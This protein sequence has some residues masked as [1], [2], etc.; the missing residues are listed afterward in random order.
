MS[1]DTLIIGIA[2]GGYPALRE[3]FNRVLQDVAD[4]LGDDDMELAYD[5]LDLDEEDGVD[6]Q[7][8]VLLM[9]TALFSRAG[10]G[11]SA[12]AVDRLVAKAG[13]GNAVAK[14]IA[15]R[16]PT[17]T[18]SLFEALGHHPEGGVRA[19]DM[20]AGHEL[21][22]MDDGLAANIEA[23][24]LFAGRFVA[25]GP[26]HIGFGVVSMLTRAEA[27]ALML[28]AAIP[29]GRDELHEIVYRSDLHGEALVMGAIEPI[30][31]ALSAAINDSAA[32]IGEIA[33]RIGKGFE[34]ATTL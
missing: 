9:D 1:D 28:A 17:A 24:V 4:G 15:S 33:R 11:P 22:I 10:E 12:R 21:H 29:D 20:L 19:R 31:A 6:E 13:R 34:A 32:P 16:L 27:V 7:S 5:L 18:F 8:A 30:I 26:W 23:G 14:A 25:L 3:A 2:K